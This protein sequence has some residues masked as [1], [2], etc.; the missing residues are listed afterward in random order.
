MIPLKGITFG[1]LFVLIVLVG[2]DAG[3][4]V[5]HDAENETELERELADIE[6]DF[7]ETKDENLTV[8]YDDHEPPDNIVL[9]ELERTYFNTIVKPLHWFGKGLL[10]VSYLVIETTARLTYGYV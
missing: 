8:S 1:I 7:E 3:I 4:A 6:S 2:I 10:D 5:A 9:Q